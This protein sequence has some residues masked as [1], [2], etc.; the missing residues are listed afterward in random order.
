MQHSIKQ[1]YVQKKDRKYVAD[2][3]QRSRVLRFHLF[4]VEL[5][6]KERKYYLKRMTLLQWELKL[7]LI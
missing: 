6:K 1:I 5:K 4:P 7:V 3:E 2:A